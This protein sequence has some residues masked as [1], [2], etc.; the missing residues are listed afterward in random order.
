MVQLQ[1]VSVF[2]KDTSVCDRRSLGVEPATFW[3][4]EACFATVAQNDQD[5]GCA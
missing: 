1:G 5:T 3:L 4:A 2:S